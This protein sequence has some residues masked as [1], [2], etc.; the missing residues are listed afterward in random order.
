MQLLGNLR[1]AQ[2]LLVVHPRNADHEALL[3]FHTRERHTSSLRAIDRN[4]LLILA[5]S[6]STQAHW[7]ALSA[8]HA[9]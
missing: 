2:T 8:A 9:P 3:T 6:C 4:E 7:T 1:L 5:Y